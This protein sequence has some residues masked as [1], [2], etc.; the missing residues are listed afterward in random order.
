ME[1]NARDLPDSK[2]RPAHEAKNL[3]AIRESIS[4]TNKE[5][6]TSLNPMGLHGLSQA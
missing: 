4:Y 3:T 1:M 6:P 2:G 5:A